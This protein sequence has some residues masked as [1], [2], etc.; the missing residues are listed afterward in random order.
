MASMH[1]VPRVALAPGYDIPRVIKGGWQLAGGH[2][3]IDAR[4]AIADMFHFADAGITAFDCADIYTG[5]EELIGRF[6]REWHDQRG[7]EAPRIRVHTK[8]VPDLAALPTLRRTD[9]GRIIDRS[10][11]RLGTERLDLV[12][13]H[14][15]D[16][17]IPGAVDAALHLRDLQVAGKIEQLGI[18][19][20]DTA[21]VAAMLDAGVTLTS[22]Q[23][24]VSL[25]DRR[26]LGAMAARC[27]S[28]GIGLLAYG[29][30]A[31]GFMH[32]RWLGAP[33]PKAPLENRSLVKYKLIIDDAGGWAHFQRLLQVLHGVA[34]THG[35]TIGAVAVRAVLDEPAVAA[36]IVGARH[37]GHLPATLAATQLQ[38]SPA[39]RA[40]IRTIVDG[41]P[42]LAGD[43]YT[44]EREKGGRH[45]SIMRYNLNTA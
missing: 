41:A 13:F 19:N 28:H 21:H 29:T 39:D 16:Y 4:T 26:A 38:L 6:L 43:V 35:S 2:G 36:T 7:S 10:L 9:I 27:A 5:V 15:W 32:E 14:W 40:A 30:L 22:H 24:Q 1:T 45:A 34:A 11:R 33:E 18:T 12:Q 20:F 25:L 8:C 17:D 44:L 42:A 23:V 31:G 3:E 37:A